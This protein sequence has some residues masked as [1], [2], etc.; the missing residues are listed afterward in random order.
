MKNV[1][2]ST[3]NIKEN[4]DVVGT[5]Y[6]QVAN[7]GM[8][9]EDLDKLKAKYLPKME[10]LKRKLAITKNSGDWG[11]L[12][13]DESQGQ[14]E[15]DVVLFMAIEELKDRARRMGANAIVGMR[16]SVS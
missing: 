4:Y 8:L 5:V 14:N 16:Q 6:F 3:T 15:L 2:V 12:F 11:F 13:G 1:I 9:T 10:E 7:K